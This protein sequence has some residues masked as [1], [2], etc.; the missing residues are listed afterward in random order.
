MEQERGIIMLLHSAAIGLILYIVMIYI[1]KQKE[2]VAE[3]RSILIASVI[4]IYMILF[5]H[6]M[7]KKIN[8]NL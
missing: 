1:F 2:K 6:G 8:A 5:G 4:L 3:N 7:P